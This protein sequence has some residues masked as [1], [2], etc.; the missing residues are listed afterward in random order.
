MRSNRPIRLVS[1]GTKLLMA[2][3]ISLLLIVL[4]GLQGTYGIRMVEKIS[5]GYTHQAVLQNA[6]FQLRLDIQQLIMPANDYLIHQ[7]LVELKNFAVLELEVDNHLKELRSTDQSDIDPNVLNIIDSHLAEIKS[8]AVDIFRLKNPL[9]N[10]QAS[11]LMESLDSLAVIAITEI[12]NVVLQSQDKM[13]EM[14]VNNN[15]IL[16][17]SKYRMIALI[18]ILALSLFFGGYYY[19]VNVV[20]PLEQLSATA[21]DVA[22]GTLKNKA[23][24][25]AG[26]EVKQFTEHFNEMLERIERRTISRPYFNSIINRISDS[27]IVTDTEGNIQT[28]NKA[29]EKLLGYTQDEIQGQSIVSVI[30]EGWIENDCLNSEII[31]K[32]LGGMEISN[33]YNT[34]YSKDR[35]VI[36]VSFSCSLM[37]DNFKNIIGIV[38]IASNNIVGKREESGDGNTDVSKDS[39]NLSIIG[40]GPLTTREK[41]IVQLIA[42][43]FSNREIAEELHISIRTVE[44][45][46]SNIMQKLNTKTVVSLVRYAHQNGLV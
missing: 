33:V 31:K 19:F 16:K 37:P 11:D 9:G 28:I 45:H 7:N 40:E 44:T 42:K 1:F 23:T 20:K 14:S 26:G 25:K 13:R 8:Y 21:K 41:E 29:T 2:I 27:I 15:L 18:S 43:D 3:I 12:E 4:L 32:I 35:E 39:D 34:Y 17:T 36:P 10:P 38:F 24:V 5:Q 30:S 6:L 22:T 46:R